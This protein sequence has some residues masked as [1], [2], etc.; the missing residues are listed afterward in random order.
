MGGV[1]LRREDCRRGEQVDAGVARERVRAGA[2]GEEVVAG[3]ARQ[4]VV[5]VAAGEG[6]GAGTAEKGVVARAAVDERGQAD[7]AADSLAGGAG[8]DWFLTD[9]D[10]QLA[11][12]TR[13]EL[14]N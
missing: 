5:A 2:A 11:D 14:V 3:V 6:V 12:R 1:V 9:D 7:G 8:L 13:R 4:G 10:D